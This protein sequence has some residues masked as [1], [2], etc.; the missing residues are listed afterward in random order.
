MT[1][2]Y[3]DEPAGEFETPPTTF[4]DAEGRD[5]TVRAAD[6]DD[7]AALVEM[8]EAFDPADRAQGIPPVGTEAISEWLDGLIGRGSVDV[9]A[10]HDGSVVG[11]ATLVPDHDDGYELAIFV[12]ADYQGA[13]IG[14]RLLECL[15]GHGRERGVE[16]VWLTVERW[17]GAAVSL[18]RSL[19]FETTGAE[20]FE[21]EMA[22]RLGDAPDG[23]D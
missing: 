1:R 23:A 21:L 20:S 3:P 13:G 15:L 12:L 14:T 6:A 8:Y 18:Y 17:N 2:N 11:H 4:T 10:E 5:V 19:G 9:V 22:L 16:K 7:V